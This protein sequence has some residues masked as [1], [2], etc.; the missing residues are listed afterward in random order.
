MRLIKWLFDR[1][2]KEKGSAPLTIDD[3]LLRGMRIRD[4]TN[5]QLLE[6]M[7]GMSVSSM[8]YPYLCDEK[9]RRLNE[10]YKHASD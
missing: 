2:K 4:L 1:P 5:D 10:G 3:V 6:V 9:M 7:R 8:E